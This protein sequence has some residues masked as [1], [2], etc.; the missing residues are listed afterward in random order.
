MKY[1]RLPLTLAAAPCAIFAPVTVLLLLLLNP[2]SLASRT[3]MSLE[4]ID[5]HAHFVPPDYR[6]AAVA[7][8]VVPPPPVRLSCI[9]F[10]PLPP[11]QALYVSRQAMSICRRC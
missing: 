3:S 10:C 4:K 9:F 1:M 7:A 11:Q 2:V 8:G 6:T 5:V